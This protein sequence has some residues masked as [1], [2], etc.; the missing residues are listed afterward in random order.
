MHTIT[1]I[2]PIF[3]EEKNI[4]LVYEQIA[5]TVA[6]LKNSIAYE[7]I[8]IDDGSRDSSWDI[9]QALAARDTHVKGIQFIR[10]FGQQAALRAGYEFA[11]GS[12]AITMDADLQDPP[13]LI[14]EMI[15]KWHA[16]ADIVYARRIG[17]DDPI[18]K[19][20][21]SHWFY[22]ILS[23][24]ADVDIPPN[25]CHYRL[26][27][28]KVIEYLK[29]SKERVLYLQGIV[30]WPGFKSDF[31][32]FKRPSRELGVSA[33]NWSKLFRLA[34]DGLTSFSL[35][36]LKI[37]AF[38]GVFI[39]LTG[40]GMFIYVSVDYL[41][42]RGIYPLFKWLVILM[43]IFMGVQFLLLW[44]LGEYIGR[45]FEQQKNRPWYIVREQINI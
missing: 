41:F 1:F 3:N 15:H 18:L 19:K 8:F 10:N 32:D 24:V 36:P 27:D 44:I 6:N 13:Q 11:S 25:V 21:T 22:K 30:A 7:I 23:C 4:P 45:I 14:P 35:F 9:I 12:A 39:I 20:F 2:L 28:R 42:F 33:Y 37:A 26:V 34:F 29:Q 5:H 17:R 31:V 43:Y 16:G 40:I 38:V